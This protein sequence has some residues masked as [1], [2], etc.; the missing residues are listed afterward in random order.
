MQQ[1]IVRISPQ[2]SKS[3]QIKQIMLCQKALKFRASIN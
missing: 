3:G 1:K 2:K